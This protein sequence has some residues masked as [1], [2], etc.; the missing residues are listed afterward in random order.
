MS[1]TSIINSKYTLPKIK[2]L[3]SKE[4]VNTDRLNLMVKP[5][6]QNRQWLGTAF[7]YMLRFGLI[8][9]EYAKG[10][11]IIAQKGLTRLLHSEIFK[12]S[13]GNIIYRDNIICRIKGEIVIGKQPL[14]IHRAYVV[15]NA[16]N[17][18]FTERY[19]NSLLILHQLKPS[20][21]LSEEEAKAA[22]SLSNFDKF[23]RDILTHSDDALDI[24]TTEQIREL[25][26]LYKIIPWNDFKPTNDIILNPC[27]NKGSRLVYGADCDLIIDNCIVEIK[28]VQTKSV[29]IR[30]L[31]QLC[32]Y[33]ILAKE[34]GV[35]NYSSKVDSI[36][37][38][39]SRS[40]ILSKY[41]VK[42]VLN[43]KHEKEF[44]MA[45]VGKDYILNAE[46][47]KP[48]VELEKKSSIEQLLKNTQYYSKD[49]FNVLIQSNTIVRDLKYKSAN[50]LIQK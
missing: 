37:V 11:N 24:P 15:D 8:A 1:L 50:T 18:A 38:Y 35:S 29:S 5:E 33:Y 41:L 7:D 2:H 44:L 9:R 23:Y 28:T 46:K 17:N 19:V 6:C 27:F 21:T 40:G 32:G 3:I 12:D 16:V 4:N 26:A 39:H 47:I 36:A 43:P 20:A 49:S 30:D 13:K 42:D 22:F 14:S 48:V 45:L 10:S 25:Q 31:R 34:F